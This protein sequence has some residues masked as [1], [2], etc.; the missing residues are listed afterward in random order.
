MDR[1]LREWK[2]TD[3]AASITLSYFLKAGLC[4]LCPS[5]GVGAVFRGSNHQGSVA[6]ASF[7]SRM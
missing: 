4:V 5:G 7:L 6:P 1:A 3:T 2:P